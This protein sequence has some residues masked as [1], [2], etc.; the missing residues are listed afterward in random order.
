MVK[1]LGQGPTSEESA[2]PGG[3][4]L[5]NP[6]GNLKTLRD[7]LITPLSLGLGPRKTD[8]VPKHFKNRTDWLTSIRNVTLVFLSQPTV[9]SRR[10]Q[11][12]FF[13][14]L[15]RVEGSGNR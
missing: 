6:N 2:S 11:I 13:R 7:K 14:L 5:Y 15:S 9:L 10:N 8:G 4:S 12:T 3:S 1:L